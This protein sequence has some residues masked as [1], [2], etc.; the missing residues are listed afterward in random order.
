[1]EVFSTGR[2]AEGAN[3]LLESEA[4]FKTLRADRG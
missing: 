3:D 1:M 4:A 2:E